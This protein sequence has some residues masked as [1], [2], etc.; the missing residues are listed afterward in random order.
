MALCQQ[1]LNSDLMPFIEH[2]EAAFSHNPKLPEGNI[3]HLELYNAYLSKAESAEDDGNRSHFKRLA[4]DH[5]FASGAWKDRSIKLDNYLWLVDHYYN[6]SKRGSEESFARA[7]VLF[8]DLLGIDGEREALN[9]TSDSLFL[10]GEV[11][12][13][14]HLLEMRGKMGEKVSILE[15]LAR[16]QEDHEQ[17]PWKLKRRILLEL[18]KSYEVESRFQDA[19]NSYRH[20]VKTGEK[21][22]MIQAN[23]SLHLA[24]LEFRLLKGKQKASDSPEMI[25]ILHT[26]KDLQI[27]KKV[28]SEPLHL[29]AALNYAEIRSALSEPESY[30]KN[31]HFFYKR[32]YDD[33]H[34]KEDPISNEYNTIRVNFP[35]KSAVYDAYMKY[36]DAQM[37]KTEA[38]MARADKRLEKSLELED[39]ALE[40]L[41]ALLQNEDPLKPYLL[42]RVKRTKEEITKAI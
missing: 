23:A 3:L 42:D 37:L 1:R 38:Q 39:K 31:A 16:K 17:L 10:E 9:I 5:L 40:I 41:D 27:Q 32:M 20:L 2:A 34:S 36:L 25:A 13:F 8:K 21:G 33:F 7:E 15:K 11:L 18:A 6:D 29:E 35:D 4:A 28:A 14:A 12:K 22:S 26:L 30:A 19:L 24:K